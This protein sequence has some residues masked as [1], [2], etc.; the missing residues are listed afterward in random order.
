MLIEVV[1]QDRL[2]SNLKILLLVW[3]APLGLRHLTRTAAFP[4]T[5]IEWQLE[6]LT[7][8]T[9][10]SA[11]QEKVSYSRSLQQVG[12]IRVQTKSRLWVMPLGEIGF[13]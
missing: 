2:T 6:S 13:W 10:P 12:I 4:Q 9:T 7:N 3:S 5:A 1:Y 8:A 11:S